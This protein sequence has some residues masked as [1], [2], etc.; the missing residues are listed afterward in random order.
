[1]FGGAYRFGEKVLKAGQLKKFFKSPRQL[2][3]SI[4]SAVV[5]HRT[6]RCPLCEPDKPHYSTTEMH[7]FLPIPELIIVLMLAALIFGPRTLWRMRRRHRGSRS[8]D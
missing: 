4:R 7:R 2:M 8:V 5:E 3:D 6:T 1:M